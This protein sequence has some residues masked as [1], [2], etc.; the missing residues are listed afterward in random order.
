MKKD[1]KELRIHTDRINWF[2]KQDNRIMAI[3][4]RRKMHSY[5]IINSTSEIKTTQLYVQNAKDAIQEG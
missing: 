4:H 1:R 3:L 2:V 5:L